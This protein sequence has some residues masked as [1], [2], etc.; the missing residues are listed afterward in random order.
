MPRKSPIFEVKEIFGDKDESLE[1]AQKAAW[2]EVASALAAEIRALLATGELI[3]ESGKII[4]GKRAAS[5]PEKYTYI[6]GL[7][8]P[9]TDE[10]VYVGQSVHPDARL[11]GHRYGGKRSVG[12][13]SKQLRRLGM[14][15]QMKIL[16]KVSSDSAG[17]AEKTW[18]EKI[19]KENALLNVHHNR[20]KNGK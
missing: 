9:R 4:P 20:R 14:A 7:T 10:T 13:L 17:D 3:I 16:D 6:Y 18:I 1:E 19:K 8:D 5:E 2:V 11:H 12:K 15:L